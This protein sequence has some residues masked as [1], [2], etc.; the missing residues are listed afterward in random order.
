MVLSAVVMV[1]D[2]GVCPVVIASSLSESISGSEKATTAETILASPLPVR[3]QEICHPSNR[4]SLEQSLSVR[5]LLQGSFQPTTK[6]MSQK[7]NFI[8]TIYHISHVG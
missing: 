1:A 3:L 4:S 8:F 2:V 6:I 5:L 7:A